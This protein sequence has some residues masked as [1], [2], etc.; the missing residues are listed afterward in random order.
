MHLILALAVPAA[1]S[2]AQ[3]DLAVRGWSTIPAAE[4]AATSPR[5]DPGSHVEFTYRKLQVDDGGA[6]NTI[7]AYH[8]RLKIFSEEGVR[9]WDKVDIPYTTGWRVYGIRARVVF[10][11]SSVAVLD[12][13]DVYTRMVFKDDRFSGYARSFSFPG[14]KPGCIIEYEWKERRAFWLPTLV[15]PLRAEWPTWRFDVTI[16]PFRGLA[17]QGMSFHANVPWE[18]KK[19]ELSLSVVDQ[20]AISDKPFLAA[21]KDFEPWVY[22]EYASELE[23]LEAKDY[24]GYRG[25]ALV[26]ANKEFINPKRRE[27][28]QLAARIFEGIAID[29]DKLKAA[30]DY[31]ATKLVNIEEYNTV[32]TEQ[33]VEDLKRNLDPSDTIKRGYGTRYDINAVFASLAAAAGFSTHL[34]AVENHQQFSYREGGY[35]G[36]N[37]SDWVVAIRYGQVWRYF[38]PARSFLPFETLDPENVAATTLQTDKKYYYFGET[39]DVAAEANTTTRLAEFAINEHGDLEGTVRIRH[40]GYAGVSRKRLFVALAESERKDYVETNEWKSRLPRAKIDEFALS[41]FDSREAPLVVSYRVSIPGYADVVGDRMVLRP[42]VFEVEKAPVFLDETRTEPLGFPF[43]YRTDDQITFTLPEGYRLEARGTVDG[44]GEG[45]MLALKTSLV[46]DIETGK[47]TF[48]RSFSHK[49]TKAAGSN[50]SNIKGAFAYVSNSD[51]RTASFVKSPS[52]IAHA[53]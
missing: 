11:D 17:S 45:P 35:G 34:A 13:S 4:L 2:L 37:L 5:V 25:G 53:P 40:V 32:Y 16:K 24:W 23:M 12:S 1:S 3:A 21:R 27:V 8:H 15:V 14:L 49:F 31:C 43:R 38:D 47:S 51:A 50:Y 33:E 26:E 6:S 18:G 42:S 30:Y 52:G 20:P 36:F 29:E 44:S 48:R 41:G 22:L 10:P 9:R 7:F 19:G 46:V 39:P 28:K